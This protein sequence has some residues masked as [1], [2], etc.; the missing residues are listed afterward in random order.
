MNTYT[1]PSK[2]PIPNLVVGALLSISWTFLLSYAYGVIMAVSPLAYINIFIAIG[3][4][5]AIG[6]GVRILTKMA[7][8][9]HKKLSLVIVLFCG[10]LGVYFSWV[11]YILYFFT[12]NALVDAYFIQFSLVLRPIELIQI[13]REINQYGLWS[14]GGITPTGFLLLMIWVGEAALIIGTPIF[15]VSKQPVCPFS[16]ELNAWYVKYTLSKDFESISMK[17]KFRDQIAEDPLAAI[18][19]LDNGLAYHFAR[20]SVYYLKD[21]N[22]QYLSVEN[23]RS[24]R[25]GKDEHASE[26]IHLFEISPAEAEKLIDSFRGKK[27]FIFDY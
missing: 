20:I 22:K 14:I 17:Q 2:T 23:V 18:E 3:F 13:I 25:D 26:V 16:S 12:D 1:A 8:V 15:L 21:A 9:I 6:F 4:G 5:L 19:A 7:K 11:V 10:L 24:D 27:A